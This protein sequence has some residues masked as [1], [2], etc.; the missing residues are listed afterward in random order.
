MILGFKQQFPDGTLTHFRRK[1]ERDEKIHSI[2]EDRHGRWRAGRLIQCSH[3]V[4]TKHFNCFTTKF[5]TG[6][7]RIVFRWQENPRKCIVY[8]D[9]RELSI[10]EIKQLA[11]NDG[12]P[13]T[14]SFLRFFNEDFTGKIIHWTLYRY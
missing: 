10:S 4:R 11:F 5:C 12:F 13:D 6:T 8:V 14:N 2:R 3:S 1:I 7:Q 9:G